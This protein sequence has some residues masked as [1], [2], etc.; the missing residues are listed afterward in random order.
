MV[1]QFI[2]R[3]RSTAADTA[4]ATRHPFHVHILGHAVEVVIHPGEMHYQGKKS[5]V[6]CDCLARRIYIAGDAAR[7]A[8]LQLLLTESWRYA[9]LLVDCP[10]DP[11]RSSDLFALVAEPL[12]YDLAEP[13]TIEALMALEPVVDGEGVANA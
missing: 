7:T 10:T 2:N 13:G 6:L 5:D 8:R 12:L 1:S 11:E 4:P 3:F 9:I